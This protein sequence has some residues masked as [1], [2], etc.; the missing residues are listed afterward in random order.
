MRVGNETGLVR[1]ANGVKM[2][3]VMELHF[4]RAIFITLNSLNTLLTLLQFCGS[5]SSTATGKI[6]VTA[7]L[8]LSI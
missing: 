7:T 5:G 6:K 8:K 4:K 2:F 1:S 3:L